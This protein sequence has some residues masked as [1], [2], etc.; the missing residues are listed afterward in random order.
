[1]PTPI[2]VTVLQNTKETYKPWVVQKPKFDTCN[3]N[4]YRISQILRK[5]HNIYFFTYNIIVNSPSY[6]I[7]IKHFF[8]VGTHQKQILHKISKLI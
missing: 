6:M 5:T 2:F 1:M 4:K 7:Q 8:R 3:K